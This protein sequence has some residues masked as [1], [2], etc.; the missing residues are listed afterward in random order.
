MPPRGEPVFYRSVINSNARLTYGEAQ[1]REAAPEILEQ[2]DLAA[3]VATALRAARF[4]RGALEVNSTGDRVL[5][6]ATA[7]SSAPGAR[8]SRTRT[9][10]SRS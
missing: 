9:C 7:G 6:R 10:W 4:A 8:A 2:L 5:V 1:R 3:E